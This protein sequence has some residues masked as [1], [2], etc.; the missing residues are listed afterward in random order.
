MKK[1]WIFTMILTLAIGLSADDGMWMPHQMKDLNLQSQGL[2]MNP[3]DLYKA[4]GTGLMSAVVNLGGG[5]GEFISP[6]GLI[7]TNH[8]VA[9]GALQRAADKDHDYITDGFL[10]HSR[11]EEIQAPGYVADVLLRYEEITQEVHARLKKNL[12]PYDKHQQLETI[13]KEIVKRAESK[14][15]DLYCTIRSMYSG[16]QYYLYT[17]KRL[18]DVRLVYAP[19]LSIGNFGGEVDNWMWPRH[20]GDFTYLRAYVSRDNL[21]TDYSPDNVPYQPKSFLTISLEGVKTGDFSFIMGYP[22]RTYRSYT[23]AQFE[24]SIED[25]RKRLGQLRD[26]I[27]FF[28]KAGQ[29]D[30]GIQIKYAG[31]IKGLNNG[32]KNATGKLEGFSSRRITDLKRQ[33]E[34]SFVAGI[35]DEATRLRA[36]KLLAD[37]AGFASQNKRFAERY[38]LINNLKSPRSGSALLAQAVTLFK[39][40]MQLQKADQKREPGFQDRDLPQLRQRI[41]LAERSYDFNTD[42]A[43]LKYIL[44][45]NIGKTD[46]ILPPSLKEALAAGPQAIDKLVDE[47]FASTILADADKRLALLKQKPEQLLKTG[48][49]LIKIAS[50]IEAISQEFDKTGKAMDQEFSDLRQAYLAIV[51]QEQKMMAP[52]ANSTI[53]FTSGIIDGYSPKDALFYG[54]KTSLRGVMEKEQAEYPFSVPQ[55]LKELYAQKNFGPY[56]DNELGDISPCFLNTTN[57]TGGNSGSPTLNARGEQT[58]IIFDMTYESV[59]GDYHII[60]ELQRT[61]S[62]D[63]RYVLFITE[64]FSG[65]GYLLKE[66]VIKK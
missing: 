6:S 55:K 58:G 32:L 8:H 44:G 57:V 10:A 5:T 60:P 40:A 14:G 50:E 3:A 28:E 34:E 26:T 42:K 46:L 22:G 1:T 18:K 63:I 27:A 15:K 23:A 11:A 52:D 21:G 33:E 48:D 31:L 47:A 38:E 4:D 35:K 66:M 12:K 17:F 49:T 2:Q 25:L 20:T 64:K 39:G 62:V 43:Y 30:R 7:L 24:D 59:T 51:L 13:Q 45:Q 37:I 54:P 53:R 19:P 36:R 9:F 41:K 56:M 16:N 61:I 65:A 29:N